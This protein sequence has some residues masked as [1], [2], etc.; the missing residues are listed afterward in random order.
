MTSCH[1]ALLGSVRVRAIP[2][3]TVFWGVCGSPVEGLGRVRE[4]PVPDELV[5][6]VLVVLKQSRA[7]ARKAHSP[8]RPRQTADKRE[9][10]IVSA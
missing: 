9:L 4:E 5:A 6:R 2:A 7:A 8:G 3:I 1:L 10:A